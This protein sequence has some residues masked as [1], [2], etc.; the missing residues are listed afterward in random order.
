MHWLAQMVA[1]RPRLLKLLLGEI[2]PTSG[3]IHC[4]TK[5]DIA[6]FDQYRAD[7]DPEKR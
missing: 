5:L 2:K 6:Y 3:R 7:L 4:G 1:E